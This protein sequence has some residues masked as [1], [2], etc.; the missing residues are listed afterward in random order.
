MKN[1][2]DFEK[3]L[4]NK[5]YKQLT[6]EE[7]KSVAS[8]FSIEDDYSLMRQTLLNAR[9][10]L[11]ME[12]SKLIPHPPTHSKLIAALRDKKQT[13][14]LVFLQNIFSYKIPIYQLGI[15]AM[16]AVALFYFFSNKTNE[17]Q[18]IPSQNLIVKTD[19]VFI[20]K[21]IPVEV[22]VKK[23]AEN[24]SNRKRIEKNIVQEKA[25][26]S[27]QIFPFCS[28]TP[29]ELDFDNLQIGEITQV[30]RTVSEDSVLTKFVVSIL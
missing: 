12:K 27:E 14:G 17:I 18:N 26:S 16:L 15:A 5:S 11:Q 3:L 28:Y 9:T 20:Y 21:E 2:I 8:N 6:D 4:L 7:K 29:N 1:Q 13:N 30:G 22:E 23:I 10:S 24:K 25:V 19:T